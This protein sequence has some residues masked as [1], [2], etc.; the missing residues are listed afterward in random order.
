MWRVIFIVLFF[1]ACKSGFNKSKIHNPPVL[2]ES[3]DQKALRYLD[4]KIKSGS[5]NDLIFYQKA[6]FSLLQGDTS[7]ALAS[8]ANALDVNPETKSTSFLRLA[9]NLYKS[10]GK[11]EDLFR[12]GTQNLESKDPEFL[13][14]IAATAF[15]LDKDSL[16][17]EFLDKATSVKH[18]QVGLQAKEAELYLLLGDTSKAELLLRNSLQKENSMKVFLNLFDIYYAKGELKK[19]NILMQQKES[20]LEKGNKDYLYRKAI[21]KEDLGGNK[22]AKNLFLDLYRKDSVNLSLENHLAVNYYYLQNYDSALFYLN[23]VLKEEKQN[24]QALHT[25]ARVKGAKFFYTSAI[26][27]YQKLMT[28]DSTNS[29][30]KKE[31]KAIIKKRKLYRRGK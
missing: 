17:R 21:L 24:Y 4:K 23:K 8:V 15:L 1:S 2:D 11:Y 30:V 25:L 13:L 18:S 3:Y 16:G 10:T 6:K 22:E 29:E 9:S 12:L 7:Q 31:Y 5:S 20:D 19:A 28:L 26:N 14:N 27:L